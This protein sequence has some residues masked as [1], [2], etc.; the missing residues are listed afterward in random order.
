MELKPQVTVEAVKN[1]NNTHSVEKTRPTS[2]S[3]KGIHTCT[4]KLKLIIAQTRK[5]FLF[6]LETYTLISH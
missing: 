5:N 4:S 2:T 1:T 3:Q 6:C